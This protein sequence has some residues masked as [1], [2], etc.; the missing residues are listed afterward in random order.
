SARTSCESSPCCQASCIQY[1][2]KG[3]RAC[4]DNRSSA[5]HRARIARLPGSRPANPTDLWPHLKACEKT[6]SHA[7]PSSTLTHTCASA[8]R[9]FT[10]AIGTLTAKHA[11][12]SALFP[13]GMIKTAP[14]ERRSS[15][16]GGT[17]SEL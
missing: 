3:R 4:V 15:D 10:T 5:S 8:T 17:D 7:S 16:R 11:S 9:R 14:V 1:E 2:T 6:S 13:F 12:K